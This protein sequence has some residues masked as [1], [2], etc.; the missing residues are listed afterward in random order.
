MEEIVSCSIERLNDDTPPDCNKYDTLR[1]KINE[2]IEFLNR[3]EFKTNI[4]EDD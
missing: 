2:I 3:H 1:C 4:W